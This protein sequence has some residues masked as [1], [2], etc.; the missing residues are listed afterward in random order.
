[1][2]WRK[3]VLE[4]YARGTLK[5]FLWFV[6]IFLAITIVSTLGITTISVNAGGSFVNGQELAFPIFFGIAMMSDFGAELHFMFQNGVS[7][8]AS[9]VGFVTNM[10]MMSGLFAV[11]LFGLNHLFVFLGN[12]AGTLEAQILMQS[13][14]GDYLAGLGTVPG[15]LVS[16]VFN[17]FMIFAAGV[18]GYFITI[19]FY[20]LDKVGRSILVAVAVAIPITAPLLDHL[21]GGRIWRATLWLGDRFFGTGPYPNPLN[22]ISVFAVVAVAGLTACWLLMRRIKLKKVS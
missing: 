22:S 2:V 18:S 10:L 11:I 3:P 12:L 14:F 16:I 19:L 21:I 8:R 4:Y 20:R 7:R 9:F 17:W 15:A 6:G 5:G 1:M 13:I